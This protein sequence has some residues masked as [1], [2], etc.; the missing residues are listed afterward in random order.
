M[1][2][3]RRRISLLP[4]MMA[5]LVPYYLN[6]A[7]PAA[8]MAALVLLVARLDDNLELEAML[9]GGLSLG[10]IAAPLL[11]FGLVVGAGE[12]DRRRLAG[13]AW[14]AR[15][16][17]AEGRRGQFRAGS[18]ASSRGLLPSSRGLAFTFDRRAGDGGVGG[19]F[20]WQ[21]L[22]DGR[23]LGPDRPSEAGSASSPRRTS[24]SARPTGAMSAER[25]GAAGARPIGRVRHA[26]FPRFAA[27]RRGRLGGAAGTRRS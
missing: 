4:R 2:A 19:A 24:G 18:A 23:E 14:P 1:A 26:R 25:P 10:R 12:P 20:V 8:F 6:L 27:A 17:L 22:A 9:A 3:E 21:R 16:Q 13:A 15:F 11:A 7:L 5:Q